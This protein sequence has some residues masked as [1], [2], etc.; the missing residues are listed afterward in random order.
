MLFEQAAKPDRY[1]RQ[2]AV[3]TLTTLHRFEGPW[4]TAENGTVYEFQV[5]KS[6]TDGLFG[7]HFVANIALCDGSVHALANDVQGTVVAAL[8]TRN[9]REI[10]DANDW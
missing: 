9:G 5:N 2:G 7:F 8:L 1:E 3:E 6:N 10:I 4:A